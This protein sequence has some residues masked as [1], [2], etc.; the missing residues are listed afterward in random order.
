MPQFVDGIIVAAAVPL[1]R[2]V[3]IGMGPSRQLAIHDLYL[4]L[5]TNP[6]LETSLPTWWQNHIEGA[7]QR[8]A[9]PGRNG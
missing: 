5:T 1:L 4:R 3:Q 9:Q 6:E 8:L 2:G 7:R